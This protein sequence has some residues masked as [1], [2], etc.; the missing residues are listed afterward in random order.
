MG[1]HQRDPTPAGPP[2]TISPITTTGSDV[3]IDQQAR[4]G[5]GQHPAGQQGPQ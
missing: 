1:E 2:S 3:V 5:Q 4:Q